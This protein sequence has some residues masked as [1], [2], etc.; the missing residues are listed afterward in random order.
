MTTIVDIS[1]DRRLKLEKIRGDLTYRKMSRMSPTSSNVI[2]YELCNNEVVVPFYY[3]VKSYNITPNDDLFPE[4]KVEFKAELLQRQKDILPTVEVLLQE[5][6]CAL[7]SLYCGFGKTIFAIKLAADLISTNGGRVLVCCH[8][9]VLIDQWKLS[10]E[11]FTNAKAQIVNA[12]NKISKDVQF[13]IVNLQNVQKRDLDDFDSVSVLIV[14][15][16]HTICTQNLVRSMMFVRPMFC[17]GLSATPYREDGLQPVLNQF[18]GDTIIHKALRRLYSVYVYDTKFK[19]IPRT[20]DNDKLDW[21]DILK[22]QSECANRNKKICKISRYFSTRNILILCKRVAHAQILYDELSQTEEVDM[23]TGTSKSF[24][25]N[26]RILIVTCSKG[27]VGFDHPKLDML[28]VAADVENLFVQYLGRV[29]RRDDT[30]PIVVDMND[31]F[32]T[33][34]QHLKT[35]KS[36]YEETCGVVYKFEK[37]FPDFEKYEI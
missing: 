37:I 7:L 28:I 31:N 29:F 26:A 8:R 32:G 3:A 24:D 17:I 21:N 9:L 33:L 35:R 6:R 22:Q 27:G 4:M 15:E 14:D 12:T 19:P 18:F 10:I 13:Y 1:Q 2:M 16:C 25:S 30:I 36:V 5:Q 11:K 34:K 20:T 23:F